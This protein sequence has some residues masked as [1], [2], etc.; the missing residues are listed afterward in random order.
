MSCVVFPQ[1][2]AIH[3]AR[4]EAARSAG[5]EPATAVA[6]ECGGDRGGDY[7]AT[8]LLLGRLGDEGLVLR[9]DCVVLEDG[10]DAFVTA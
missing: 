5:V 10:H 7:A 9:W 6:R 8:V 3:E 2:K 4:F 1:S